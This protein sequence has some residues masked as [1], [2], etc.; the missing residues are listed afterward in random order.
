MFNISYSYDKEAAGCLDTVAPAAVVGA[1]AVRS[2][3]PVTVLRLENDL[4]TLMAPLQQAWKS[5]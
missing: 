4:L 1:V 2:A 3:A 5:A